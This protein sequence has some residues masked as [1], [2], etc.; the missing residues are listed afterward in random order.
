MYILVVG[1]GLGFA[2]MAFGFMP[3]WS[4]LRTPPS[5]GSWLGASR[6][7]A[8]AA[9]CCAWLVRPEPVSPSNKL[10]EVRALHLTFSD[11][12]GG[13][14]DGADAEILVAFP[15]SWIGMSCELRGW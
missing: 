10:D 15:L 14:G 13:E 1:L 3:V 2:S 7:P 8:M 6:P 4:S 11:L 9:W 5:G 12:R